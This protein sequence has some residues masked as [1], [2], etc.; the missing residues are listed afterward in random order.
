M[1]LYRIR[2]KHDKGD[3]DLTTAASSPE[4]AKRIILMAERAP[5]SAIVS[6]TKL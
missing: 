3:F 4:I 5:E 1:S 6:V 2:I